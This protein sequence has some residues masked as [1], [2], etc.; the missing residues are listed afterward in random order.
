MRAT[1]TLLVLALLALVPATSAAAGPSLP[2]TGT[3]VD[4]QLGGVTAV[5][6]HVGIVVRDRTA[7]PAPGAYNVCYV[8]AFQ[9]QPD[10]KRFWKKRRSLLLLDDGG[11]VTD[12]AWGEWLLDIRTS[13]KRERIARIVGR[14]IAGCARDGFDAVELDN[15]DSFTRSHRLLK[16]R[17]AAAYARLLT[18]RAHRH[19]LA[20]AQKNRAGW[21][22]TRV[23]FDFAVAEECGR[24]D[25]CGDYVD[26][27]GDHVLVI[28]YREVDFDRT[29]AAF[30]DRLAIVL[31]DRDVTPGGVR[32]WC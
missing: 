7:D 23:G 16:P 5:P 13:G 10:A 2:P 19:D 8:N 28:E 18:A 27:Y 29:C 1:V 3:D 15:L 4:Y 11:I 6:D 25:E 20:V 14:W 22:G 24:Y 26:T 32:R 30:G 9:T 31:R 17:H 12:G 21:D